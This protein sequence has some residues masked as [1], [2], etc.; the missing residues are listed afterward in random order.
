MLTFIEKLSLQRNQKGFT[1]VEVLLSTGILTFALCSVLMVYISCSALM[2]TSKN[3]NIATNA[4]LGLMEEIRG[5]AFPRIVDDYHGLLFVL[6][7]IPTSRGIV[8]VDD[9]NS[10]LLVVT[11]S[12]CW[13]QGSRVIGEDTNLDGALTPE[14]DVNNNNIIDSPVQLVTRIANR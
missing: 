7:D 5:S 14:E 9:T 10:E 11:I 3:I 6:N 12:V 2:A 4:A 8:Y 1:L 13:L